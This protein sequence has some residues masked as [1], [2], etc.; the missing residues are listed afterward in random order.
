MDILSDNCIL[1]LIESIHKKR[2]LEMV[3]ETGIYSQL[4]FR[5]TVSSVL[6]LFLKLTLQVTLVKC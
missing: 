2:L 4:T 6:M 3:S 5:V 1:N